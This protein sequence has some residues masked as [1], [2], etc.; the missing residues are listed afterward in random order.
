[1]RLL[2]LRTS[3]MGDVALLTPVVRG[4]EEQYKDIRIILVT[5]KAF[6]SF[7]RASE[8]LKLFFPDFKG[9]HRGF[10]GIFSLFH[11]L[12]KEGKIDLVVDLHDVIRTK[13]LRLLF[14]M[15]GTATHKID[16]GR[17]EKRLLIK[18]KKTG[19]LKHVVDRY[20]ETFSRAGFRINLPEGPWIFPYVESLSEASTADGI[21]EGLNIGVA[22]YAKHLLK[23]WPEEYMVELMAKIRKRHEVR[24]WLFGGSDEADRLRSLQ[25]KIP[26][27]FLTAGKMTLD[28][29]LAV[30]RRLSLM[31]SM[32]SSNMH[33]ASLVGA[34]VISIWGATDPVAG[35]GAWGQPEEYFIRIPAEELTCRPCTVYGKGRC[36]RG[37]H[38]CMRW[39]TPELVYEKILGLGIL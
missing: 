7:F 25:Q 39:L 26:G 15:A 29:E 14:M 38:A 20:A 31:I 4:L 33:M 12:R 13:I 5:R 8:N 10:A 34:R 24:F 17:R 22:P 32:D 3:A 9:R 37:D 21:G 30:M 6:G 16:K 1:M 36:R 35:F 23:V 27:S 18:G 11:D 2:V 19:R 28:E